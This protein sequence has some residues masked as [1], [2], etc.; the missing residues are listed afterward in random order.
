MAIP[1]ATNPYRHQVPAEICL[2]LFDK[3]LLFFDVAPFHWPLDLLK[4]SQRIHPEVQE[5]NPLCHTSSLWF[6][7]RSDPKLPEPRGESLFHGSWNLP[8]IFHETFR[9]QTG[10][11]RERPKRDDDN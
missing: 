10:N 1:Y 11:F 7:F 9:C 8:R 2:T 4:L 6:L 3:F 5:K